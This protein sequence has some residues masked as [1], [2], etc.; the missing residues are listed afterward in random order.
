M[1]VRCDLARLFALSMTG[2]VMSD[3]PSSLAVTSPVKPAP[4]NVISA[5]TQLR[6]IIYTRVKTR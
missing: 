3:Y 5:G 1:T 6:Q 2:T 4:D